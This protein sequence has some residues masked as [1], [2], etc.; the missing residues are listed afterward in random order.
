MKIDIF[1]SL[2]PPLEFGVSANN[3]GGTGSQ[4][5]PLIGWGH[6][7]RDDP[8]RIISQKYNMSEGR[9]G[10]PLYISIESYRICEENQL[11]SVRNPQNFASAP[12]AP[13]LCEIIILLLT[14]IFDE[15]FCMHG[16]GVTPHISPDGPLGVPVNNL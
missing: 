16:G 4:T 11:V 3:E 5:Y 10:Y 12:S 9:R 1:R 7:V 14:D 13:T 15:I 6:S 2:R 8:R